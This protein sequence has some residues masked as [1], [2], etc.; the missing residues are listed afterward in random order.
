MQFLHG[1]RGTVRNTG[2]SRD[3]RAMAQPAD[4]GPRGG[5]SVPCGRGKTGADVRAVSYSEHWTSG[6][7]APGGHRHL[8]AREASRPPVPP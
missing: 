8:H 3:A 6:R 4:A 1:R 5:T 7:G 2:T